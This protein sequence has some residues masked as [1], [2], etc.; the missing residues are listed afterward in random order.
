MPI[1]KTEKK[2]SLIAL[3]I[4]FVFMIGIVTFYIPIVQNTYN[5]ISI[6]RTKIITNVSKTLTK[7]EIYKLERNQR[8]SAN[9]FEKENEWLSK[10]MQKG[11][12]MIEF[13]YDFMYDH[14]EYDSVKISFTLTKYKV[15][16]KTIEFISDEG[17]ITKIHSKSGWKDYHTK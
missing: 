13:N 17:K 16:G 1:I 4:L 9:K 3:V 15:D 5:K 12:T 8:I 7:D 2:S 14:P 10:E 6:Q 11:A